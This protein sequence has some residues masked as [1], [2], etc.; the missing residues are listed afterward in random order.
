MSDARLRALMNSRVKYNW[1]DGSTLDRRR[2]GDK[3]YDTSSS[4]RISV[5]TCLAAG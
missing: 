2:N 3:W 4:G 5:D 1:R